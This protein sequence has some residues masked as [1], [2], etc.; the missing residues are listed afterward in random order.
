MRVSSRPVDMVFSI[1]GIFD[2]TLDPKA[3]RSH[4]RLGATIALAQEIL[5]KGGNASW[6]IA[7]INLPPERQLSSFPVFPTTRVD[8]RAQ[9]E[10]DG[11]TRDLVEVVG[12]D[13]F[14][15]RW[16]LKESP[17]GSMD[18][19]EYL[20]I[21]SQAIHV[22]PVDRR[23]GHREGQGCVC[24]TVHR[25]FFTA[26]DNT[27]WEV[28][29]ENPDDEGE[30]VQASCSR[31]FV[32][33]VGMALANP[34][35][36]QPTLQRYIQTCTLLAILVQEHAPGR[37]HRSSNIVLCHCFE[38][39]IKSWHVHEFDIGPNMIPTHS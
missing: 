13:E 35:S 34:Y 23:Q 15:E 8:G 38:K 29:S 19:D 11:V 9:I 33:Y 18:D 3:F 27:A 25:V 37:Y 2:V 21:S 36:S 20:T 7:T 10:V 28:C 26:L 39:V 12:G 5:R 30:L 31:A 24:D 4:D 32:V 16:S 6:L 22:K 17:K 1:M 14:L